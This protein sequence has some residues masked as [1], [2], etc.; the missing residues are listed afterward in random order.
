MHGYSNPRPGESCLFPN[1]QHAFLIIRQTI[2]MKSAQNE[3]RQCGACCRL[4]LINLTKEEYDSGR[5]RAM[6]REFN[7]FSDFR[8]AEECGANLLEQKDDGSCIY[9]EGNRCAI[10]A[11]RPRVCREFFCGSNEPRFQEMI[12]D[13]REFRESDSGKRLMRTFR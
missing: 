5:Y 10:H 9:L 6:F 4:F 3:C 2:H 8:K 13:I 1:I 7:H 12:K 11:T